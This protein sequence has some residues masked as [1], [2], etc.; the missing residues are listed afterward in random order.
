VVAVDNVVPK[1]FMSITRLSSILLSL[2]K[3]LAAVLAAHA[4]FV[5][6]WGV[7]DNVLVSGLTVWLALL[8]GLLV[9]AATGSSLTDRSDDPDLEA[10]RW[11]NIVFHLLLS[12]IATILLYRWVGI[13]SEQ[14]EF[15]ID[16]AALDMGLAWLAL[17]IIGYVTYRCFGLP[18]LLVFGA[19][20][21]Y[22]LLPYTWGGAQLNWSSISD[23]QW[24]STDGVF[25]R[26]V[27]V[28]STIVLIFIV[29][30]AVLQ[31]SG[32]GTVLMKMT[33]AAT[34]RFSG[35]PAH[36]S[37]VGSALFGTMSGAAVA[38]VVSTGVFTIPII[39]KAGFKAKFAG[40]V[41][42]AAST[43]GQIMPPVMGVVAFIMADVTGI[44]YLSI[45]VAAILPA[46]FYYV[47][48]FLVVLI[49]A[50]KQGIGPTPIEKRERITGKDWLQSSAFWVPLAI[51]VSVLLTGRTAQNAGF[52][53]LIAAFAL[54]NVLFPNFR[55]P[56]R[57]LSALATAGKT[58]ASLMIIVAAVGI[59]I[60]LVNM[61]GVGLTFADKIRA[62]SADS[63]FVAL[64][65]VMLGCLVMG[66]GVPTVTA[67][68][69]LAL[70][71]GPVLENMGIPKIA[72]HMFMLYFGVLSVLTPPVAL[73][74]FAAAPLAGSQPMETGYEA[75]RLAIAGFI[76]PFVFVYRPD[77]LLINGY[78]YLG[79]AVAIVGFLLATWMVIT[80]LAR[81][82][83]MRISFL[84]SILR[85]IA[86]FLILTAPPL[87][88]VLSVVNLL[89][90]VL[91]ASI[92][93]YHQLV[94]T[95]NKIEASA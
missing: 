65:L 55:N 83:K 6:G 19:M 51:I 1:V 61:S 2:A 36:A 30:G 56:K 34:G 89:G 59:V 67:Y 85:L 48:L 81:H 47:S 58:C 9:L 70:V 92:W 12:V 15:F 23:R 62:L 16:I 75:V 25:G 40:A 63:L 21:I 93:A 33:F 76:I 26:P 31:A 72:A 22:A 28:V 79:L 46:M 57:W 29:F 52:Y 3:V 86:A 54:T 10:N 18:M 5:A 4:I 60:G 13:M 20:I 17:V 42:A 39:K 24:F 73:A 49:E 87:G 27:Q 41:E 94:A 68:L 14:Q 80:A 35:G 88:G 95:K 82:E 77:I 91:A 53:A 8:I 69:V 11:H 44:S 38:N 32:A 64:L 71:M 74:A 78:S 37:I 45:V 7:Y 84:E 90:F 66:M 43:G 50:R